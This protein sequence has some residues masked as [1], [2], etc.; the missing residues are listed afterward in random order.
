V[1][2]T[3]KDVSGKRAVTLSAVEESVTLSAVEESVTLSA[4]EEVSP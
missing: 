3:R 1:S 2:G 4:V